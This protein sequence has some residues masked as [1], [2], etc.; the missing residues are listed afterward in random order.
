MNKHYAFYIFTLE[1]NKRNAD[2]NVYAHK[3]LDL[4]RYHE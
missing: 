3:E 1:G 4:R 2:I